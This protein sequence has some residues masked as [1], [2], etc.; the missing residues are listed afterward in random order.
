MHC[1]SC[2]T[3]L[4]PGTATC[5]ACGVPVAVPATPVSTSLYEDADL[6]P[7]DVEAVPYKEFSAPAQSGTPTGPSFPAAVRENAPD[8]S[9][10][11]PTVA[12]PQITQNPSY[13]PTTMAYTPAVP[14]APQSTPPARPSRLVGILCALIVLLF[15]SNIGLLYLAF[16]YQPARLHTEEAQA[17]AT[18]Y[19][20]TVEGIYTHYTRGK[21][22]LDDSLNNNSTSLWPEYTSISGNEIC[23]FTGGSL[24]VIMIHPRQFFYCSP[25]Y[26]LLTNFVFQVQ[27]TIIKG[28][29]G[30]VVVRADSSPDSLYYFRLDPDGHFRFYLYRDRNVSDISLLAAGYAVTAHTGLRQS[31]L[32]TVIAQG[33]HFYLYVNKQNVANAEDSTY[34]YGTIGLVADNN[35][36]TTEVAYN[37][38]K[39][40]DLP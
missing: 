1:F 20:S 7:Y 37:N 16:V 14:P 17:A 26:H 18:A 13:A 31:N 22:S 39:L 11:S 8:L 25:A 27:M 40:W 9:A 38:A 28:N 21:P 33:S 35:N 12:A 15:L 10:F 23:K 4:Q 29:Y 19:A 36:Q 30:G 2:G 24:H 32:I 3:A 6:A 5:P 34:S